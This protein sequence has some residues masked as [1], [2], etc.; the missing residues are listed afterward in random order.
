MPNRAP[1]RRSALL[2]ALFA[3]ASC[4]APDESVGS[5]PGGVQ[6]EGPTDAQGTGDRGVERNL[7]TI[8][9]SS[10]QREGRR[11][12]LIDLVHTGSAA[13]EFEYSFEWF[14]RE[15]RVLP[16]LATPWRRLRLEPGAVV[17]LEVLA[18]D[19]LAESWRLRAFAPRG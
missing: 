17:P 18:P 14:D 13:I 19:P 7:A 2:L 9:R 3:C 16:T 5:A 11:V 6:V 8:L 4:A 12:F 15:G 1:R 10:V